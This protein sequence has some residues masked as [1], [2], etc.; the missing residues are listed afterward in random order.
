MVVK[1]YMDNNSAPCRAVR[2]TV[3]AIDAPVEIV[4]IDLAKG[5]QLQDWFLKINPRHCVPTLDD[6]GFIMCESRSILKY[7]VSKYGKDDALYPTDFKKRCS[8]DMALDCDLGFLYKAISAYYL[9]K[10]YQGKAPD[11][12]QIK[13]VHDVITHINDVMLADSKFVAGD[14]FSI[15]DISVCESLQALFLGGYDEKDFSKYP[16]V[17]DLMNYYKSLPYYSKCHSD[18][19]QAIAYLKTL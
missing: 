17:S 4:I 16:K 6:D 10:I 13:G 19:E 2:M 18:Y 1:F 8:I 3:E 14:S 7:L 11:E 5:E 12:A 15:A 9:P